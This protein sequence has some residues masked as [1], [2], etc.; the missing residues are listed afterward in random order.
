M[1]GIFYGAISF[2]NEIDKWNTCNVES[3]IH[4]FNNCK[5]F[6]QNLDSWDTSSLYKMDESFRYTMFNNTMIEKTKQ[7]PSW[8][9]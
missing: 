8:Y 1:Y 6:N 5:N 2:N 7:Y 9:K 4:L 3:M